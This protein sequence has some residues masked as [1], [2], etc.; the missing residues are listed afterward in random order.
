MWFGGDAD[1]VLKR[2]ARYA[3]G[4][5]PFLTKP[6]HLPA[7]IDFIKSQTDYNGR[8]TEVFYGM[9]TSRVGEGHVVQE[10]PK[11]RPGMTKQQIID[12]LG[13]F[14]EL[15]VTMSAIPI[16][17]VQQIEDYFDYTQWVAEEIMPVVEKLG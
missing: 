13:W 17:K 11:A 1:P 5:W 16:P 3:S 15:G 10:D 2:I 6:E 14:R 4:W 12:R 7:K 8:L 9:A